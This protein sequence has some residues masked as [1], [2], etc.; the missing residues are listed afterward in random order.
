MDE[1]RPPHMIVTATPRPS[2]SF[3]APK[4][5]SHHRVVVSDLA[6]KVA[7]DS[8]KQ[9]GSAAINIVCQTGLKTGASYTWKA[10]YWS[11][12]RSA[13]ASAAF[14]IGLADSDWGA[15]AWLGAGD[16]QFKL[17]PLALPA[18]D[19][20][21]K[22]KLHVA[23]PGGA[24]VQVGGQPVGDPVGVSLWA[25]NRRSVHYFSYDLTGQAGDIVV[26]CGP[27]FWASN[28]STE[29]WGHGQDQ[30]MQP[31]AP[32]CKLLLVA[33]GKTGQKVLL[34]SGVDPV[35][36][37][38]GPI[39]A[40]DPWRGSTIDTTV[41]ATAGWAAAKR[42]PDTPLFTPG[43]RLFPLPAPFART[44][45]EA[46]AVSVTAVS[47]RPGTFLYSFPANIVGHASV[48][49]GAV[50]GSGKLTLEY[51][52]VWDHA[53]G[54]CVPLLPPFTVRNGSR[55]IC[56]ETIGAWNAGCDSF[57]LKG[58]NTLELNPKF[59]WRTCSQI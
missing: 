23:S 20:G 8:E 16:R 42:A 3:L 48:K 4:L 26:D 39:L 17:R 25:D 40:G 31:G 10:T 52:E 9:P 58:A 59:T 24:T 2:F 44:Q 30:D 5:M 34:R 46:L 37:R 47:Q 32:S 29:T 38:R 13:S 56:N 36:G 22:V 51:C 43:G 15:A 1:Q 11:A 50:S 14:D 18:A 19:G 54:G 27:G 45:G 21:T 7:W 12:D 35:L 6:G 49:A 55:P 57:L 41:A 53:L 33:D 28:T